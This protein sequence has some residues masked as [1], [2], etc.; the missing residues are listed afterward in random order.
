MPSPRELR[1]G[2][3]RGGGG[4]LGAAPGG[5]GRGLQ[6]GARPAAGSSG[7]R[8]WR[9]SWPR[10]S[11]AGGRRRR[12]P[13][14]AHTRAHTHT[15][16][17]T[18]GLVHT[19]S[20]TLRRAHAAPRPEGGGSAAAAAA[21]A[22]ACSTGRREGWRAAPAPPLRGSL[23]PARPQPSDPPPGV[24]RPHALQPRRSSARPRAALRS[25]EGAGDEGTMYRDP[26]AASPG[27]RGPARAGAPR[28]GG[29][30]GG[31][32]GRPLGALARGC[33]PPEPRRLPPA[34]VIPAPGRGLEQQRLRPRSPAVRALPGWMPGAS[35]AVSPQGLP[36]PA[37][38]SP[39]TTCL[40]ERAAAAPA[41][42]GQCLLR[43]PRVPSTSAPRVPALGDPGTRIRAALGQGC[44]HK[45]VE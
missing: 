43:H 38:S 14:R 2:G 17:H 16:T 7:C 28:T 15:H 27:K 30:D 29:P 4:A 40:V 9:R 1:A 33:C 12:S 42:A 23:Q 6:C 35:F 3:A 24:A 18:H 45:G 21:T 13:E 11:A 31:S 44:G 32:A 22:A 5:G 36:P 34:R 25:P 10:R 41:G 26:E 8:L 20:H 19:H 39:R 37:P